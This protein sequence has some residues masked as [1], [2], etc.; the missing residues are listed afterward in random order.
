MANI[1]YSLAGA[2][3]DHRRSFH[4]SI[5]KTKKPCCFKLIFFVCFERERERK[6]EKRVQYQLTASSKSPIEDQAQKWKLELVPLRVMEPATFLPVHRMTP[7]QVTPA[8]AMFFVLLFL[9]ELL[10]ISNK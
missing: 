8:K 10:K 4:L 1:K 5:W 3:S 6:R 2:M 7:S 9:S